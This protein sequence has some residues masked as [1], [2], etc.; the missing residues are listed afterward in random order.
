MN[1]VSVEFWLLVMV[2][3]LGCRLCKKQNAKFLVI[4]VASCFFMHGG[5]SGFCYFYW[6]I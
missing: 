3:V 5:M 1:F 6:S 4:G 2:T